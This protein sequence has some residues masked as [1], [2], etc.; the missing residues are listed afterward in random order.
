MQ[1]MN[2]RTFLKTLGLGMAALAVSNPLLKAASRR[3]GTPN[4]I[5]MMADDMGFGDCG[6]TGNTIIQTPHL[7]QLCQDGVKLSNFYSGGPVCSPT[8]A[9]CLTG[10][11]YYRYGI[12]SANDGRL[13]QQEVTIPEV[14]QGIG[15]N[16]GHFGKWH[17][18]APVEGYTGQN[19]N[20][21][22][23]VDW[24]GYDEYFVTGYS[25]PLYDPYGP[26]GE[27]AATSDNPYWHNGERVLDNI[28]GDDSRI[29]MDRVIP[30]VQQ[31]NA[32]GQPFLAVIWFHAPHKDID[33]SPEH[34]AIYSDYST[35]EQKYYGCITA[36]DEQVGRL[37]DELENLGELGNTSWWFC[38]DNG[39][40]GGT[41]G[42]TGGLRGRKRSLFN[43][44]VGVPAFLHWPDF[45]DN[46]IFETEIDELGYPSTDVVCSTLDYFP[47]IM[48][49]FEQSMPDDRPIDGI[50]LMPLLEG[51]MQERPTPVPFRFYQ[52][53]HKM[54]DSPTIATM[55]TVAGTRYK[56][57]T[58]LSDCAVEDVL[59]NLDEDRGEQTN[60]LENHPLLADSLRQH[61]QDFMT[62]F[63]NSYNGG[64]YDYDPTGSWR[65]LGQWQSYSPCD[66]LAVSIY[67]RDLKPGGFTLEENY[68][69][70]FN[71]GTVI[72][73]SIPIQ[74]VAKLS[75][76]DM[77]GKQ[78]AKLV[79]SEHPAGEYL[80]Q[81]APGNLASGPYFIKLQ[82]GAN[83]IDVIKCMH[84]K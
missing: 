11:H 65:P 69:N 68:P 27:E 59:I 61:C 53:I 10:R 52:K 83:Q 16:T 38:S 7:D 20:N 84:I 23:Y 57:L 2:R 25:V 39:P 42:S 60:L 9:T 78:V 75:V 21:H 58:N 19:A 49:F 67:S 37:K 24:F 6:F 54:A 4:V 46:P 76:H 3:D 56:F 71:Q 73:Y 80:I 34:R 45:T 12:W 62:S 15:Y 18:G 28:T 33:A 70:P 35:S 31:A 1:D 22:A 41:D 82:S 36:M 81:W 47:T 66:S 44:G 79:D 64:D 51:S 74:S 30:F 40:E 17:L 13:P 8:R 26:N 63:E 55:A 77:L 32:N 5:L 50:S 48:D 14:L 72:K 43:G 29:M